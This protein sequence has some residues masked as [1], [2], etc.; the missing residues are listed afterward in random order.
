MGSEKTPDNHSKGY[1]TSPKWIET[2]QISIGMAISFCPLILIHVLL[3]DA[4]YKNW[5]RIE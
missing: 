4:Y 2:S 1:L 5:L 3:H